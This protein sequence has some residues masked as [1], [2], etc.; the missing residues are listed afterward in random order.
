MS[1]QATDGRRSGTVDKPTQPEDD[2]VLTLSAEGEEAADQPVAT[3]RN[4]LAQLELPT[5]ENQQRA[6]RVVQAKLDRLFSAN[7]ID[8]SQEIRLQVA[9][10]GQVIVANQHPQKAQIEEFFRQDPGLRDD[11]AKFSAMTSCV[12]AAQEAS[13]FQ[14]AYARNPYAAVAQYSHLFSDTPTSTTLS[15]RDGQYHALWQRLGRSAVEI[16]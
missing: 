4:S 7:G 15:I 2:V 13:A 10:D 8:T 1:G 9:G 11:F 3:L 6:Q 14:A 12:A 16:K 5:L